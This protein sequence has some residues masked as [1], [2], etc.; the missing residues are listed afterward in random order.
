V[1]HVGTCRHA[2]ALALTGRSHV[3][4]VEDFHTAL[5][6]SALD[7]PGPELLPERLARACAQVLPVDRRRHQ[8]LLRPGPAA[9]IGCE[10]PGVR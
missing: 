1:S 9:A 8:P 10:R 4:L 3:T 7:V 6:A 2:P 5:A